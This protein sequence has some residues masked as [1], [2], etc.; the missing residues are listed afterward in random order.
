MRAKI[1]TLLA[2]A[3]V[4]FIF[5]SGRLIGLVVDVFV[6]LITLQ[7]NSPDVSIFGQLVAKY[8]TWII[9][10]ALVGLLFHTLGMFQSGV[11]KIT[12]FALSTIISF[13]L[14]WLVMTIETYLRVVAI[15]VGTMLMALAAGLLIAILVRRKKRK[16]SNEPANT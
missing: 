9:A 7:F 14:S 3:I 8:G 4:I 2:L 1:A 10:Y 12:Y 15:V 6:W 11:M 16:V 13:L 5:A